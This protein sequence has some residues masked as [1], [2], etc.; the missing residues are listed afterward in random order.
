MNESRPKL[1]PAR[2][3]YTSYNNCNTY[4]NDNVRILRRYDR[5]HRLTVRR[6]ATA[7]P[8]ITPNRDFD[9]SISHRDNRTVTLRDASN[10]PRRT[11]VLDGAWRDEVYGGG[12]SR[13]STPRSSLSQLLT[14]HHSRRQ[15]RRQR[16]RRARRRPW[17]RSWW[18]RARARR[19]SWRLGQSW[20]EGRPHPRP[21]GFEGEFGSGRAVGLKELMRK[22]IRFPLA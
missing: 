20:Q 18:P 19:G 7:H 17:W 6:V 11:S 22:P 21:R 5:T 12:G 3:T 15:Q 1:P 16:R 4:P 2:L 13:R 9:E 8:T 14:L 10:V